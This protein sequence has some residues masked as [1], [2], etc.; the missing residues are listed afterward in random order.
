MRNL[1]GKT[2]KEGETKRVVETHRSSFLLG[3][4]V[5]LDY[6]EVPNVD[7]RRE[8]PIVPEVQLSSHLLPSQLPDPSASNDDAEA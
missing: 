3:F 7:H 8:P 4:H 6:A 2:F 5:G 1:I